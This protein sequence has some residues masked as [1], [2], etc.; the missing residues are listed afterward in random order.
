MSRNFNLSLFTCALFLQSL[1]AASPIINTEDH[2]SAIIEMKELI[3]DHHTTRSELKG[4]MKEEHQLIRIE[5]SLV[6]M[7]KM[8]HSGK[9][10]NALGGLKDPI[11]RWFWFWI[12]TWGVGILLT[13]TFGGGLSSATIGIIWLLAFALGSV[14]LVL[15]LLKKFG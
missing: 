15:W 10:M 14:S 5:K 7:N 13:L 2:P 12:I 11:D 6:R 4:M 8:S 1:L 3:P 9:H